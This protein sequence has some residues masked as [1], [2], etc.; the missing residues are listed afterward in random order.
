MKLL[1]SIF[2]VLGFQLSTDITRQRAAEQHRRRVGGAAACGRSVVVL[3]KA[4]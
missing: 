2:P 1:I 3:E 4:A